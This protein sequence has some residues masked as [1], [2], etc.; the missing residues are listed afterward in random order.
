[1][2]F[3]SYSEINFWKEV[4]PELK[5]TREKIK[6]IHRKSKG[7]DVHREITKIKEEFHQKFL[8]KRIQ[9]MEELKNEELKIQ[10]QRAYE[11]YMKYKPR[12]EEK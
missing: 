2:A 6:E 1:M 3:Y 11:K 12:R 9:V 7:K 10:T 8:E 4:Y 5:S